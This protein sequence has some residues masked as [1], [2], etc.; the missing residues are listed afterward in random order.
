MVV[1]NREYF[2]RECFDEY[3]QK[4]FKEMCWI[5]TTMSGNMCEIG[6]YEINII[7]DGEWYKFAIRFADKFWVVKPKMNR[8]PD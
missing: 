2:H 5:P 8:R 1:K 6:E 3:I 7:P 4:D